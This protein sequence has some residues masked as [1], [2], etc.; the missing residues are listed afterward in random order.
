MSRSRRGKKAGEDAERLLQEAF[1][2]SEDQLL[3]D[4]ILAQTEVKDSDIPPGSEDGFE[5]LMAKLEAEVGTSPESEKESSSENIVKLHE[6]ARKPRRLKSIVKVSVAAAAIA[7]MVV[8]MGI[9]AGAKRE[10]RYVVR[11]EGSIKN[12]ISLNNVDTL[13]ID[14]ELEQAYTEIVE[15]TNIQPLKLAYI[16]NNMN[17]VKADVGKTWATIY[18]EYNQHWIKVFQRVGNVGNSVNIMSDRKKQE[19]VYNDLLTQK[20]YIDEAKTEKGKKEYSSYIVKNNMYY[21]I[22]GVMSK[23]EFEKIVENL[24]LEK[25]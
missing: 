9:S 3:K 20:I 12:K 18:F 6:E 1:G 16:P 24:F 7:V 5:R 23:R 10:Y 13:V 4:F 14:D 17:F 19:Y 21:Q 15:K 22:S 25:Y 11:E 2:V 8:A